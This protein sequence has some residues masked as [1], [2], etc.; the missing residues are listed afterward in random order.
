MTTLSTNEAEH[1]LN[2]IRTS[3]RRSQQRRS[4]RRAA[5]HFFAWGVLWLVGYGASDLWPHAASAVWIALVA[6]W[7]LGSFLAVRRVAGTAQGAGEDAPAHV[8]RRIVA[9][10]GVGTL[11]VGGTTLIMHPSGEQVAAYVPLLVSIAYVVAGIWR[12]GPRFA[13]IGI[14]LYVLTLCGYVFLPSSF[15]LLMAFG[16][17]SVL[18]LT[19]A[20]LRSA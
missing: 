12:A 14:L 4:Y 18:A 8:I 11:L 1:A 10:V 5:P 15:L 3:E 7:V 20:W 9:L 16:G 6:L 19:G 2:E 13:A 17:G